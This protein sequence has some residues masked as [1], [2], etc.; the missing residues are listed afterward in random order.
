MIFKI[1]LRNILRH[2]RRTF[3]SAITIAVGLAIFILFDS[4]MS[5]ADRAS[6]ENMVNLTDGSLKI[7]TKKYAEEKM[8][9]P[10]KYGID[11]ADSIASSLRKLP[12]IAGVTPRITF[13]SE[14][15]GGSHSVRV[16]GSVINPKTDGQ[17]FT[18]SKYITDG[19]FFSS[20]G[21]YEIL[22]GK[23]MAQDLGIVVGDIIV[24]AARTRHETYNAMD[25]EVVGLL[26]TAAPLINENG[27]FITFQAADSL[28]DARGLVTELA[29]HVPWSKME[30]MTAYLQRVNKIRDK[31]KV[32]FPMLTAH[33]FYDT[34]ASYIELM[35]S[36]RKAQS[37]VTF[38]ILLI[39]AVGIVN[40]VLMSV[41]E[42]IREVGVLRALGLTPKQIRKM[43]LYEGMLIG[44]VGSVM[45]GLIGFLVNIWLVNTGL[46]VTAMYK[47]FD[48]SQFPVWGVFY[49]Q[50]NIKTFITAFILGIGVAALAAVIPARKAAKIK[51]TECLKFV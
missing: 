19:R 32:Q 7:F 49:G 41:Y 39:G 46:D 36:K 45:G 29:L 43:F 44:L 47:D 6:L 3:L 10:L 18:L 34:N 31:I 35:T 42:R 2:K 25:F 12:G 4:L 8:A 13:L 15:I 50:W 38:F 24:L 20:N 37:L 1:A 48:A 30:D 40:T 27:V 9:Y 22:L 14:V 16:I 5:G 51:P 17:V 33:T 23:K 26:E 11:N 21:A 28:L